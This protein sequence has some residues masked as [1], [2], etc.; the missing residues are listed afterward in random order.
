M[1]KSFKVLICVLKVVFHYELIYGIALVVINVEGFNY[2][3]FCLIGA[4]KLAH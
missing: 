4:C 1:K 2:L 3:D